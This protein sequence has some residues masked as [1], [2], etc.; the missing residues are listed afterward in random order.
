MA[1]GT[2]PSFR[3]AV[4]TP[5]MMRIPAA[6][7]DSRGT[8]R[9]VWAQSGSGSWTD[10][11]GKSIGPA[12]LFRFR[13]SGQK[14]GAIARCAAG[15]EW[16]REHER[17]GQRHWADVGEGGRDCRGTRGHMLKSLL[18]AV[19]GEG[20]WPGLNGPGGEHQVGLAEAIVGKGRGRSRD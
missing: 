6:V 16:S 9:I 13:S 10:L 5:S 8:P 19:A 11:D 14:V 18:A 7:R 4:S 3:G 1:V 17:Q 15:Q 2:L 20:A 12:P